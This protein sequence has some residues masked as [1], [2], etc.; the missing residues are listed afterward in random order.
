MTAG[1]PSLSAALLTLLLVPAVAFADQADYDEVG[2]LLRAGNPAG[3]L[4]RADN[5]LQSNARDPQM[6]FLR[7]VALQDARRSTEA[8]DAYTALTQAYPELA[9]PYNNLAVLQAD[10]GRLDEAL[11]LL[12]Q[13]L[14]VRPN[15]AAALDNLGD[16]HARLALRAWRDSQALDPALRVR[17]TAKQA[18]VSEALK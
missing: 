6:L 2:R 7:G 13:A 12:Q 17:N 15:Y 5:Y 10:E 1:L 8:M 11:A 3:A 9:E 18:R 14:R 4:T 16:V